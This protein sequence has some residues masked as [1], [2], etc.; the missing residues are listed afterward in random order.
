MADQF[1]PARVDDEPAGGR[2]PRGGGTERRAGGPTAMQSVTPD[3]LAGRHVFKTGASRRGG[4]WCPPAPDQV[5][6]RGRLAAACDRDNE[7]ADA[8]VPV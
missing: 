8:P 3:H 6:R 4:A 2:H 1:R 7:G 5:R